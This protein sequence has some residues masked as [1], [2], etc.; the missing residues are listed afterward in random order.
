MNY[1][2]DQLSP[3]A[4][5]TLSERAI[6]TSLTVSRY[7]AKGRSKEVDKKVT[8]ALQ[9]KRKA[10]STQIDLLNPKAIGPTQRAAYNLHKNWKEHTLAWDEKFRIQPAAL[11]DR[12]VAKHEEL[13]RAFAL[14][15]DEFTAAFPSL[16]RQAREDLGDELFTMMEFPAITEIRSKFDIK[17]SYQPVPVAGDFR[18]SLSNEELS[19]MQNEL[20]ERNKAMIAR[21]MHDAWRRLY[22]VVSETVERLNKPRFHDTVITNI[23]TIT[24][25][26]PELN[27]ANDEELNQIRAEIVEKLCRY[28]PGQLREDDSKREE[29]MVE[30]NRIASGMRM[31][32]MDLT[33]ESEIDEI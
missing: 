3:G 24:D 26:L 18:I 28:T 11:Y 12:F 14:T 9:T 20:E 16:L 8:H 32:R 10:G 17:L 7:R 22:G 33:P 19:K 1:N 15:A 23:R 25:I 27:L 30:A 4:L 13:K 21:S 2:P 6:L 31:L 5:G 29:I